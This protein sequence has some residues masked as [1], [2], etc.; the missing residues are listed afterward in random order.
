[1]RSCFITCMA[2]LF[3]IQTIYTMDQLPQAEPALEPGP[4]SANLNPNLLPS[5]SSLDSL[6]LG[7]ESFKHFSPS[8]LSNLSSPTSTQPPRSEPITPQNTTLSTEMSYKEL[9]DISIFQRQK[10]LKKCF[11]IWKKQHEKKQEKK[12]DIPEDDEMWDFAE[13]SQDLTEEQRTNTSERTLSSS[14]LSKSLLWINEKI[15]SITSLK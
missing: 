6:F 11:N 14:K 4:I 2:K 9:Y 5:S 15:K 8:E 10:Q 12:W 7:N 3:L 1:M 13:S